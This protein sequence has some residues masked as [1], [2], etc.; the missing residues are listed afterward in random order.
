MELV[1]KSIL[2]G[3]GLAMDAFSVSLADGLSSP[4]MKRGTMLKI[5]I[6]F[7]FFQGLMPLAGWVCVHTVL[8]CF[9]VLANIIPWIALGLLS[10]IG[11]KMLF[12]AL[13]RKEGEE[14]ALPAVQTFGFATLLVQGL[15]TSI[16]ALSVGFTIADYGI[17]Q[18]LACV[19]LIA[20][21]T[22][23]V[24]FAGV[25]I[26][27]RVGMKWSKGAEIFGGVILIGIGIE[28]ILSHYLG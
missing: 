21:V 25:M 2:L 23:L 8:Q 1:I 22:F 24:C 20:V 17:W 5:A 14:N 4:N 26:G 18:A 6:V 28:I 15:A 13:R 10:F 12:G 16:D 3:L 11:G 19:A 27:K 7:A 9:E